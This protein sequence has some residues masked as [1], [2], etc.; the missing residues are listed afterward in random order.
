MTGRARLIA[1]SSVLIE[2]RPPR[3]T[4]KF[5]RRSPQQ[6][7]PVAPL[8]VKVLRKAAVVCGE[9]RGYARHAKLAFSWPFSCCRRRRRQFL[10]E[11]KPFVV[12]SHD[13]WFCLRRQAGGDSPY[14]ANP[15]VAAYG[16]RSYCLARREDTKSHSESVVFPKPSR[17]SVVS[18]TSVWDY[19]ILPYERS[20]KLRDDSLR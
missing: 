18:V 17:P 6:Q 10:R 9:E 3:T 15:F 5:A 12:S 13:R 1:R 4:R 11:T 20:P 8:A 19:H 14:K 2:D 16:G 7:P